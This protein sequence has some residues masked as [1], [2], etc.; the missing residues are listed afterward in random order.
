MK[1][2]IYSRFTTILWDTTETKTLAIVFKY[3]REIAPYKL[4]I[5][6]TIINVYTIFTLV[7]IRISNNTITSVSLCHVKVL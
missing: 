6:N 2:I 1:A 5:A 3:W 7:C 4:H